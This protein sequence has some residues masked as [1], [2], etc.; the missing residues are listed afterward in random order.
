MRCSE[1]VTRASGAV[2][3]Y[4]RSR[5]VRRIGRGGRHGRSVPG[6]RGSSPGTRVEHRHRL[7]FERMLIAQLKEPETRCRTGKPQGQHHPTS[8]AYSHRTFSAHRSTTKVVL[9][10][11]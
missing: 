1:P 2:D 6:F 11:G 5:D 10:H 4:D 3:M 8:H 7:T 9:H